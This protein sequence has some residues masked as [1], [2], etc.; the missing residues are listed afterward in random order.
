[1]VRFFKAGNVV[2]ILTKASALDPALLWKTEISVKIKFKIIF[3][4]HKIIK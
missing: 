4:I 1:M 2:F 3:K